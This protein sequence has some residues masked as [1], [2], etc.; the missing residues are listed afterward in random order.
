MRVRVKTFI[1]PLVLLSLQETPGLST[2]MTAESET[3]SPVRFCV[4]WAGRR[5]APP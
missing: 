5:S 4:G 1:C 3:D 2:D